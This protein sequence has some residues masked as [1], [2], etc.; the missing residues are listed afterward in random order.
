MKLKDGTPATLWRARSV[1]GQCGH[2][3]QLRLVFPHQVSE[4]T[5]TR[6]WQSSGPLLKVQESRYGH[7]DTAVRQEEGNMCNPL[8]E[9]ERGR[10]KK[11]GE[12]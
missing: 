7:H 12:E 5:G 11:R 8:R 2:F 1:L 3:V 4:G 10:S 6:P 9:G